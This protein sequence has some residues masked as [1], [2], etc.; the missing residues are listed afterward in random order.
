[1]LCKAE[2]LPKLLKQLEES[3]MRFF[4]ICTDS[5]IVCAAVG[6]MLGSLNLFDCMLSAGKG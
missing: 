4:R 3:L 5:L 1:M 6:G 2:L